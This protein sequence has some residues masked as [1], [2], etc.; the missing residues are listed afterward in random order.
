MSTADVTSHAL[1]ANKS[2]LTPA[3]IWDFSAFDFNIWFALITIIYTQFGIRKAHLERELQE[4]RVARAKEEK[5]SYFLPLLA[6]VS[7]L[8]SSSNDCSMSKLSKI[9]VEPGTRQAT[10]EIPNVTDNEQDP[11]W[12]PGP[13][14]A[15]SKP[16]VG[17]CL[18]GY[19]VTS[20]FAVPGR[21]VSTTPPRFATSSQDSVP[22]AQ[23]FNKM[24]CSP[25]GSLHHL[26]SHPVQNVLCHNECFAGNPSLFAHTRYSA[27]ESKLRQSRDLVTASKCGN[28]LTLGVM[29]EYPAID[30][31]A[32]SDSYI[33]KP[34]IHEGETTKKHEA[35]S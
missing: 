14:P 9:P 29:A 7:D 5:D 20:C 22:N 28:C 13:R 34:Q 17:C 30:A 8:V 21:P 23:G 18:E 26:I 32:M 35:R 12:R 16:G 2:S 15:L 11:P 1:C 6:A 31:Y 3:G 19:C 4:E 24:S 33:A 10:N 27:A 25:R